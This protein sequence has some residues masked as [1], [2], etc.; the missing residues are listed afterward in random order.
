MRAVFVVL[1]MD[2]IACVA[3]TEVRQSCGPEAIVITL[4]PSTAS[5]YFPLLST[6]ALTSFVKCQFNN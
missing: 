1:K 3:L 5:L 2:S 6:L 4:C